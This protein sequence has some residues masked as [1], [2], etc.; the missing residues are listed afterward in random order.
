EEYAGGILDASRWIEADGTSVVSVAAGKLQVNGGAG[1]DGG[2]TVQF[3]E[4]IELGGALV[5]QHGEVAFTAASD[6]VLGGLYGGGIGVAGCMAG[7]RITRSGTESAIRALINGVMTG[8]S[9][10]SQAGH[11]YALTTRVFASEVYRRRQMFHSSAHPAG[12]AVGGNAITADARVV[13]EAHEIDPA[14]P[15]T[16]AAPATVLYDGVIAN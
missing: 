6:G 3:A 7:F 16:L 15:Q 2:T 14:D 5:L 13:L 1:I 10:V 9:L 8:P 4:K 11:R 12:S